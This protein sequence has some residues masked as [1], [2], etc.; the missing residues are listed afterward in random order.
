MLAA[1]SDP[2]DDVRASADYRLLVIPRLLAAT[3]AEARD[4][5]EAK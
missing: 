5:L 4:A 3:V 2:V 1:G